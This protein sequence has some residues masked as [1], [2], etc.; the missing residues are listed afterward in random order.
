MT[1]QRRLS[2]PG[3]LTRST[4]CLRSKQSSHSL[5]DSQAAAALGPQGARDP[6]AESLLLAEREDRKARTSAEDRRDFVR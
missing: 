1:G 5:W 4:K 6:G 2:P 3:T